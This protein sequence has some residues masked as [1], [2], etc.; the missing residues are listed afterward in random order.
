MFNDSSWSSWQP[1]GT[2]GV[3]AGTAVE[4]EPED[5]IHDYVTRLN[6]V[7]ARSRTG[8]LEP[9]MAQL[10][11]VPRPRHDEWAVANL[12]ERK[13]RE[14]LEQFNVYRHEL[15]VMPGVGLDPWLAFFFTA[16][17]LSGAHSVDLDWDE[18]P[19]GWDGNARVPIAEG[20]TL[21]EAIAHSGARMADVREISYV[22]PDGASAAA[23]EGASGTLTIAGPPFLFEHAK[24]ALD[25]ATGL[26]PLSC[27]VAYD[28]TRDVQEGMVLQVRL[29]V[30]NLSRDYVVLEAVDTDY[31]YDRGEVF[32]RASLG[33]LVYEEGLDCYTYRTTGQAITQAPF[34]SGVLGPGEERTIELSLKFLQAG[35]AWREFRLSYR[36]FDP[37]SFAENAYVA[38]PGPAAHFPPDVIYARL[39][40]VAQPEKADKATV[41][42]GPHAE[43][44][45]SELR[46]AYPF[47]VGRRAFSQ[48]QACQRYGEGGEAVHFSRWQQAWVLRTPEGCALVTPS[49]VTPYP[50]VQ[51]ECFILVDEVD[52]KVPVRFADELIGAFRSLPLGITEWESHQLGLSAALP[53]LRL[54]AF[55]HE[56]ERLGCALSVTQT[57][58]GRPCL[59]VEPAEKG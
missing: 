19:A 13:R 15:T 39:A 9:S 49:R 31:R 21:R 59:W 10:T 54:T 12:L 1:P 29:T 48:A 16:A 11:N 27:I 36:R 7:I 20:K 45:V 42:L 41:I 26:A 6:H 51:A 47:H 55:F 37:K 56:L 23:L 8:A 46:W 4:R 17:E 30:K 18:P 3:G 35:D 50:R 32:S 28:R 57:Q 38:V 43:A 34:H 52:Q 44:P 25:E 58:L 33:Q 22:S 2:P 53:K 14:L 24:R 5:L 40:D